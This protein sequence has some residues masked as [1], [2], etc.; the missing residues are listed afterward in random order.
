MH[1]HLCCAVCFTIGNEEFNPIHPH[2]YTPLC[3]LNLVL[4]NGNMLP[5]FNFRSI[6]C[7]PQ[8][9]TVLDKVP[10]SCTYNSM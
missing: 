5:N 1:V 10:L 2:E 7:S 3:H 9:L 6:L 4:K 8:E